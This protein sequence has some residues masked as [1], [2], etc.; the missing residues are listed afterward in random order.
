MIDL[1]VIK[2]VL[3][4]IFNI[5]NVFIQN[6][7]LTYFFGTILSNHDLD[8]NNEIFDQKFLISHKDEIY[9]L[10][11]LLIVILCRG[12]SRIGN[13]L[14][15]RNYDY[16]LNNF[17]FELFIEYYVYIYIPYFIL[18]IYCIFIDDEICYN[19]IYINY[20]HVVHNHIRMILMKLFH[21]L[22]VI[23]V[24]KVHET[25]EY[26]DAI[27]TKTNKLG[28]NMLMYGMHLFKIGICY[29]VRRMYDIVTR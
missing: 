29:F 9:Y 16:I 6:I 18:W 20:V 3:Y 26:Y 1:I 11:G 15:N 14:R 2:S 17:I 8:Y 22:N 19:E 10:Q 28:E 27:L 5:S 7:F 21:Q 24:F 23:Q 25:H 4:K 12:I 13:L